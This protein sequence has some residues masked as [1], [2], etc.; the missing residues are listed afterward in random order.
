[1]RQA[2]KSSLCRRYVARQ[3]RP[4]R[5]EASE[6]LLKHSRSDA[7]CELVLSNEKHDKRLQSVLSNDFSTPLR[8]V[9]ER[10]K[11]NIVAQILEARREFMETKQKSRRWMTP[12]KVLTLSDGD[13]RLHGARMLLRNLQLN[14][15]AAELGEAICSYDAGEA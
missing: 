4:S 10:G 1:M 6:T 15:A 9:V 7:Q 12:L 11:S 3:P 13:S 8:E 5:Q 14:L 2:A